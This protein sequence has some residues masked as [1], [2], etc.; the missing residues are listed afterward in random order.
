MTEISILS[1]LSSEVTFN[2]Y[3]TSNRTLAWQ[4]DTDKNIFQM[5]LQYRCVEKLWETS[6]VLENHKIYFNPTKYYHHI[7]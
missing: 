3:D 1:E 5:I 4:L 2:N 6:G 7:P